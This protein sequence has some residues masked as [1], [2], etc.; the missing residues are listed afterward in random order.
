MKT[1][2]TDFVKMWVEDGVLHCEYL[3]EHYDV[4]MVDAAIRGRLEM[5]SDNIYPMFTDVRRLK[6]LTRE[7]RQRLA[8]KDAGECISGVAILTNSK[9][10]RVIYNFF[11][12]IYKAPV[13]GKMFNDKEDALNW[14]EQFKKQN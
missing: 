7:G 14:L 4:T 8:Q 10:Q 11:N 6:S 5:F 2:E 12:A 13:P 3:A 1:F 9:V